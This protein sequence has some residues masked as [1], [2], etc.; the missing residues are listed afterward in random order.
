MA[1]Q[2]RKKPHKCKNHPNRS[3]RGRCVKCKKWICRECASQRKG[4]FFCKDTCIPERVPAKQPSKKAVKEIQAEE[5]AAKEKPAKPKIELTLKSPIVI[6]VLLAGLTTG[7]GGIT[8]GLIQY[9]KTLELE[10]QVRI[11]KKN[12]IKMI[13]FI[14]KRN[15]QYRELKKKITEKEKKEDTTTTIQKKIKPKIISQQ[16]YNYASSK[17][18]VSF[19]NGT[20]DKKLIALTFDGGSHVNAAVGILDTLMSRG[21]TSTMFLT[22]RLI[23]KYPELV[24]RIVAEGHEIGNHTST[25]P[26]LTSWATTRSHTTLPEITTD[27]IGRELMNANKQYRELMG[28]DM[29]PVWRAPYGEKNR[30]ICLW[31]QQY[32]YLHVGWKQA[33][34]WRNNFDTNDWVPDPETPG[35]HTPQEI[36]DKFN[37]LADAQP[38]GM[39]GAIILMHLGTVRKEKG[40]QVHR[41]MGKI[42]DQLREKGYEFVTVSVLLKESGV[43]IS[44]LK[45][46]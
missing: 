3:A 25:H 12:R 15:S 45:R 24:Q 40:Q 2:K 23:R 6:I 38:Y 35:Y 7:L 21:V 18:P 14:K 13:K 19:D 27:V 41:V 20:T 9:R 17:L 39:N 32:G 43:D 34:Y 46:R 8:F 29:L 4:Q 42:I 30:Q 1:Q 5:K 11:F 37:E 44:M 22:R 10:E 31:A 28:Y 16:A 33:R 36:L 26:H